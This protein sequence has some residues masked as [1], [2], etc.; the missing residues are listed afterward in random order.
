[1]GKKLPKEVQ[2]N[3]LNP[4]KKKEEEPK[5]ALT[6]FKVSVGN[7]AGKAKGAVSGVKDSAAVSAMQQAVGMKQE[8]NLCPSLTWRQRVYGCCGCFATGCVLSFIGWIL[9]QRAPPTRAAAPRRAVDPRRR[10]APR[11]RPAP[12]HRRPRAPQAA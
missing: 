5:T 12:P 11:R 6:S 1:M 7:A 8:D 4:F 9:W 10:A 2:L 3:T